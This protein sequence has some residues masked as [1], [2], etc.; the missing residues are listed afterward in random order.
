MKKHLDE[1]LNTVKIHDT[2]FTPAYKS[3]AKENNNY[4]AIR[5]TRLK[6]GRELGDLGV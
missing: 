4:I 6:H 1:R 3:Y 2:S 5:R